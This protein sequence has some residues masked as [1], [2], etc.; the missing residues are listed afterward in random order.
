MK[1]ANNRR[2]SIR[3]Y[4]A[5]RSIHLW[6][7][8][9]KKYRTKHKNNSIIGNMLFSYVI[10][11]TLVMEHCELYL[12][13]KRDISRII[14]AILNI[15]ATLFSCGLLFDGV[16]H[17]KVALI[18]VCHWFIVQYCYSQ[19]ILWINKIYT[20]VWHFFM[21]YSWIIILTFIWY[22]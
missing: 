1:S 12:I 18:E 20:V 3:R 10:G 19:N 5:L 7:I 13:M 4:S 16:N 8:N 22:S 17:V 6:T 15:L 9:Q 2:R 11:L 21:F 14:I